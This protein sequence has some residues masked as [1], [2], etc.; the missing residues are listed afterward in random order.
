MG[1]D[2]VVGPDVE[3]GLLPS[4]RGG[5]VWRGEKDHWLDEGG[6]GA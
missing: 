5:V 3:D 1:E 2:M 4:A 6:G